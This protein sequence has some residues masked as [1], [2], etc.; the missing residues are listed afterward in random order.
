MD[1][2]E[3]MAIFVRVAEAASFTRAAQDLNLPRATVSAAVQQLETRFGVRLLHRSTRKVQMTQ[4]GAALLERCRS[5]LDEVEEIETMFGGGAQVLRGR[6]KLDAPSRLARL[7]LAPQLPKFLARYPHLQLELGSSDRFI[8]IVQEGVDVA[9]RVG[10]VADSS[11]VARH[12]CDFEM[13]NCASPAYLAR[14]G[15]PQ[16]VADLQAGHQ[17][18]HYASPSS[19]R[20]SPW[21]YVLQGQVCSLELPGAVIVNNA[22]TYLACTLAGLGLAQMPRY[23]L[24]AHLQ[25]GELLEVLPQARAASMPVSALYSHRRHLSPK[26]RVLVDW[27][28]QVLSEE[29]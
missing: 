14:Y 4:D 7:Q 29:N 11:L 18:V 23:G 10:R 24:R 9:L 16:T 28:Q 21:E 15:E 5:V 2:L 25:A 22:E 1:K 6:L 27:L 26:I 3:A 8:D 19:G 12:L 13:I 17:V 20:I